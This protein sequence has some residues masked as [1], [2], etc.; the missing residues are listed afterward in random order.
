MRD[1]YG[2]EVKVTSKPL[3]VGLRVSDRI[4]DLRGYAEAELSP[5]LARKL[6]RKLNKAAD[7]AERSK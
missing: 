5:D 7:A 3:I 2:D 1:N 6:A 4:T